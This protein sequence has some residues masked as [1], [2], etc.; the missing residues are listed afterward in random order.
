MDSMQRQ[1]SWIRSLSLPGVAM[2]TCAEDK[3]FNDLFLD[4]FQ[5]FASH[6]HA[7]SDYLLLL[8]PVPAPVE[9]HGLDPLVLVLLH[10]GVDLER[11]L[12]GRGENENVGTAT[13]LPRQW[14]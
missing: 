3:S 14:L 7:R 4:F 8:A 6:L 9:A 2:M 12:A 10:L 1:P 13:F 5:P 11:E